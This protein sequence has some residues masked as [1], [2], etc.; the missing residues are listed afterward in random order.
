M[1]LPIFFAPIYC[2]VFRHSGVSELLLS[3]MSGDAFIELTVVTGEGIGGAWYKHDH[4]ANGAVFGRGFV[5][6]I[7]FDLLQM[8]EAIQSWSSLIALE[9]VKLRIDGGWPKFFEGCGKASDTDGMMIFTIMQIIF[10][11]FL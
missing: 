2:Q 1:N 10:E 11:E 6:E 5:D 4:T 8:V 3:T 7:D 9:F